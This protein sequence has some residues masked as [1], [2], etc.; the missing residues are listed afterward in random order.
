MLI[1]FRIVD[2][3]PHLAL[4]ACR[5]MNNTGL[6]EASVLVLCWKAERNYI[7][8]EH[9]VVVVVSALRRSRRLQI[10]KR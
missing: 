10:S 4:L 7:V 2:N 3:K 9:F 1:V 8:A 6:F 5:S